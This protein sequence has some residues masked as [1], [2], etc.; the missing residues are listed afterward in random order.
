M[1]D[2]VENVR[3]QQLYI[4]IKRRQKVG[5]EN[6]I[7]CS[8]CRAGIILILS[9]ILLFLFAGIEVYHYPPYIQHS[10]TH[11]NATHDDPL[12]NAH[13]KEATALQEKWMTLIEDEFFTTITHSPLLPPD[14]IQRL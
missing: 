13:K 4:S 1:E 12:Y 11:S 2:E 7:R 5:G 6:A 8:R 3:L 14:M 9:T 10:S